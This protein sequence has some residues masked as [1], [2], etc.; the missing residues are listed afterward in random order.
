M[1]ENQRFS[2]VF[3]GYRNE[4]IGLEWVKCSNYAFITYRV[5]LN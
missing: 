4:N 5:E 3:R 1:S 2:D